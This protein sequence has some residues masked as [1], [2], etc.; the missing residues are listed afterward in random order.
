MY[1]SVN[2][3]RLF[4]DVDGAAIVPN[5]STMREKPTLLLLHGGPGGYHSEFKPHFPARLADLVQIVYLDH[6]GCGRSERGTVSS[7]NLAQWGDDVHGFCEALGIEQ[8]IVYGG[9][10]GGQV[11][12]SFATRYP[13]K[14]KKLILECTTAKMEIDAMLDAFERIGG[15]E[16]RN[17]AEA[18]WLYPSKET[19]ARYL[20]ICW[21]LYSARGGVDPDSTSRM[22]RNDEVALHFSG[23]E[24]EF[25]K[26]DY[27]EDLKHILCPTLVMAGDR[28]PI[29]PM[30][31]GETIVANLPKHLVQ[32]E[33]FAGCG[34]GV[35]DDDPDRAFAVIR[36]FIQS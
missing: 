33:R 32:F 23:K 7:W 14:L 2:G 6:R 1:L 25:L 35:T 10:F 28:D 17:I 3:V 12:L 11:A 26:V 5:G 15:T 31:F 24:G 18:R 30:I 34:H 29:T 8:P 27:R 21:P 36:D 9:S 19:R 16:A 20:E 22:I 13:T 4:F